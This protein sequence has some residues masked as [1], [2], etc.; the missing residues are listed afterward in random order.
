M[1][2]TCW[3]NGSSVEG[4]ILVTG[5]VR[6]NAGLRRLVRDASIKLSPSSSDTSIIIDH[7]SG[8]SVL[9]GNSTSST[10]TNVRKHHPIYSSGDS[11]AGYES[12]GHAT[13]GCGSSDGGHCFLMFMFQHNDQTR[14]YPILQY[15]MGLAVKK[16]RP[17]RFSKGSHFINLAGEPRSLTGTSTCGARALSTED[18]FISIQNSSAMFFWPITPQVFFPDIHKSFK[19]ITSQPVM[20]RV[21]VKTGHR[22]TKKVGFFE[23]STTEIV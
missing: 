20:L 8:V 17:S 3:P 10:S 14:W 11:V 2:G 13:G 1:D 18:E 12:Q 22:D 15:F 7:V 4:F 23:W 16:I 19:E 9:K 5:Q 6:I 21:D